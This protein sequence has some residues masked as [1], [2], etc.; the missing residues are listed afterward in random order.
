[1]SSW[2]KTKTWFLLPPANEVWGKFLH[3]S[4]I[5]SVHWGSMR[6]WG[7]C[8][9]GGCMAGG[10]A[11]LGTW[12]GVCMGGG[13]CGWGHV[14]LRACVAGRHVWLGS[15][16]AG[17]MHWWGGAMCGWG[18]RACVVEGHVWHGL[19]GEHAW[20]GSMCGWGHAWWGACVAGGMHGGWG[21]CVKDY[22]L[23][24]GDC[25]LVYQFKTLKRSPN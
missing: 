24:L 8:M 2:H 18:G 3:L 13:V 16:I 20:L 5:H 9:A 22:W 17:S 7:E 10:H 21:A 14:W 6:G 11:W 1:M 12:L 4:V 19:K 15:C 25:L 23:S